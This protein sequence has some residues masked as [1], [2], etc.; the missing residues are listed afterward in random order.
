M[1]KPALLLIIPLSLLASSCV[2]KYDTAKYE[3]Q[4]IR[5]LA[6]TTATNNGM[7]AV[8]NDTIPRK[9]LALEVQFAITDN[10]ASIQYDSHES[11]IVNTNTIDSLR[12]WSNQTFSGTPAGMPINQHF[13]AL[14]EHYENAFRLETGKRLTPSRR[15]DKLPYYQ[16]VDFICD[17]DPAP[18]NYLFYTEFYFENGTTMKDSTGLIVIE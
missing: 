17:S 16:K 14:F 1:K 18:G 6:A 12:I 7:P 9:L 4:S 13:Y 11:S 3:I 15:S 8:T 5:L 2:H 10:L